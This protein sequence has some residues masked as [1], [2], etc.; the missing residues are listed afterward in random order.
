M[1]YTSP[2]K[3]RQRHGPAGTGAG[4]GISQ[5]IRILPLPLSP[6]RVRHGSG[7]ERVMGIEPKGKSCEISRV[8]FPGQSSASQV[9]DFARRG[10]L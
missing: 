2:D 4:H 8:D 1:K 9:R 10:V 7:M 6:Q 5:A 3:P